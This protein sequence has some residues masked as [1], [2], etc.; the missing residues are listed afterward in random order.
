VK[1]RYT[2]LLLVLTIGAF[3]TGAS[4]ILPVFQINPQPLPPGQPVTMMAGPGERVII[5]YH[6]EG[7]VNGR[8]HRWE[9]APAGLQIQV[10][11]HGTPVPV[12]LHQRTTVSIGDG[13]R[14]SLFRFRAEAEGPYVIVVEDVPEGLSLV[15]TTAFGVAK[16]LGG[17]AALGLGI[18][19]LIA[20]VVCFVLA[21]S[22]VW[23]RK[24]IP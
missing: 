6:T 13:E 4:L 15:A 14:R 11:H 3:A 9:K 10:R 20:T 18:L 23:P 24:S 17:F 21:V 22:Q 16:I 5:W 8:F 2:L 1:Y 12:Q 7:L 19:L